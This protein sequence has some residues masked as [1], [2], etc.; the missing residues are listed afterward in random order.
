MSQI[1][2]GGGAITLFS[3][4]CHSQVPASHSDLS[5]ASRREVKS[6][7]HKHDTV[8]TVEPPPITPV[9]ISH[10]PGTPA[11]GWTAE[12]TPNVCDPLC[13]VPQDTHHI[14]HKRPPVSRNREPCSRSERR[15]QNGSPL[16]VNNALP[17][18]ASVTGK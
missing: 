6:N 13:D 8:A 5:F 15:R 12:S 11:S 9:A 7:P 1:A 16:K 3:C 4:P 17:C 2:D 14:S 18:Q 10:H